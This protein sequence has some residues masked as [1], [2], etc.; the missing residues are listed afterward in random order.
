[1]AWEAAR[2]TRTLH[3]QRT[4]K[5][6]KDAFLVYPLSQITT[7]DGDQYVEPLPMNDLAG[8]YGDIP[9]DDVVFIDPPGSQLSGQLKTTRVD[10]N[11]AVRRTGS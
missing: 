8:G 3:I 6:G 4:K 9:Y 5:N 10:P 11:M 1:M 7:P 2:M